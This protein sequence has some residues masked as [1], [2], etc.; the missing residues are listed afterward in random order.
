ML[1]FHFNTEINAILNMLS[2]AFSAGGFLAY[3][4][5]YCELMIFHT[6]NQ[7]KRL[8]LSANVRFRVR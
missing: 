2:F 6:L 3:G 7:N 1:V 4:D 8:N 5:R